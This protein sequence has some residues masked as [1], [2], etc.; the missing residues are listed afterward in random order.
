MVRQR[1]GFLALLIMLG[2]PSVHAQTNDPAPEVQLKALLD[3]DLDASLRRNPI[4]AT[5]RGVP[6]YNHLLPDLSLATLEH[7]RARER[8]ALERLKSFIHDWGHSSGNG[9]L[10]FPLS[11][12][13]IARV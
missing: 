3:E 2:V 10:S 1:I 5:V 8:R 6:G 7:E 12:S 13:P 11:R 9:A 4:Q